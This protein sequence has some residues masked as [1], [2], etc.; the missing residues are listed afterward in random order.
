MIAAPL[1][2]LAFD[3]QPLLLW[4]LKRA[5]QTRMIDVITVETPD[6]ALAELSGGYFDLFLLDYDLDND[7]H[8]SLLETID[9][10]CPYIPVVIMTAND[11]QGRE[12]NDSIRQVRKNGAWHLLEKPF[13]LDHVLSFIEMIFQGTSTTKF[14]FSDI[15]HNFENERRRSLR[16]SFVLPIDFSYK[17]VRDGEQQQVSE[18]AILTDICCTGIG[19]LASCAL[20]QSQVISL[21]L[22]SKTLHGIVAWSQMIG[23]QTCRVGIHIC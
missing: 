11:I 22:E 12:V 16:R 19:L 13:G 15:G 7:D 8:R 14:E 18:S 9:N 5:G 6:E 23:A 2:I 20:K 21:D 3:S 17:Q 10:W 1:K 4:A